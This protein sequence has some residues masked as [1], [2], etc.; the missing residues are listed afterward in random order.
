MWPMTSRKFPDLEEG[1]YLAI[2]IGK[3]CHIVPELKVSSRFFESPSLSM[4]GR[5]PKEREDCSRSNLYTVCPISWISPVGGDKG[6]LVMVAVRW[7]GGGGRVCVCEREDGREGYGSQC[8]QIGKG[9][10]S[11][12]SP[13]SV[14]KL[15]R[16]VT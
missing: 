2:C 9:A 15:P 12:P 4:G 8:R 16:K 3:F 7:G 5:K 10:L 13:S 6:R 1:I 14:S 11:P